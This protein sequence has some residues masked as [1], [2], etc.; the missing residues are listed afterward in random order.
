MW[1]EP[2]YFVQN[3]FEG[4]IY[5][6]SPPPNRCPGGVNPTCD[7]GYTG[8]MCSTCDTGYFPE[9]G[10]CSLCPDQSEIV[11]RILAQVWVFDSFHYFCSCANVRC[12]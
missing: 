6:C 11:L 8:F 3:E 10:A 2:G 4:T 5:T 7:I 12:A 9:D 1:A